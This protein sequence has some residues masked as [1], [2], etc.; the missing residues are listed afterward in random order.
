MLKV[1]PQ[2]VSVSPGSLGLA[3]RPVSD[4]DF[5]HRDEMAAAHMTIG[6]RILAAFATL[7]GLA[8]PDAGASAQVENDPADISCVSADL[9]GQQF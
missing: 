4:G 6:I 2:P 5:D 9:G 7:L 3:G 8:F 1:K